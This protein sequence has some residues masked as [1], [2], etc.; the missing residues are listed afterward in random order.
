MRFRSE[1]D[2]FAVVA[3]RG[4]GFV[5]MR[6]VYRAAWGGCTFISQGPCTVAAVVYLSVM[7]ENP[8]QRARAT[9]AKIERFYATRPTDINAA[10]VTYAR[11]LCDMHGVERWK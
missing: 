3:I 5:F 11:Y 2:S 6:G 4:A 9:L 1:T 10:R 8:M 7:G